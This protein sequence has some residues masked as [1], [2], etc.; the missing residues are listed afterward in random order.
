[1]ES[2]RKTEAWHSTNKRPR[3]SRSPIGAICRFVCR[4]ERDSFALSLE[5]FYPQFA[6]K[7]VD[8][9]AERWLRNVQPIRA[10][11][12]KFNSSAAA[13]KYS[14]WRNFMDGFDRNQGSL[15]AKKGEPQVA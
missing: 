12:V 5:K 2:P 8:L 10:A 14:R 13:T 3:D 11:W 7:I 9:L 15:S 4:R 6:F 1:V